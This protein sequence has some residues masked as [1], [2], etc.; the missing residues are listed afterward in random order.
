MITVTARLLSVV[1][2]AF[3]TKTRGG[4]DESPRTTPNPCPRTLDSVAHKNKD[5][6]GR[7][8][9]PWSRH[10][11]R[12]GAPPVP[13][14]V[15]CCLLYTLRSL[16][17]LHPDSE[18]TEQ[19]YAVIYSACRETGPPRS[20]QPKLMCQER[21]YGNFRSLS[22]REPLCV[23]WVKITLEAQRP[24]AAILTLLGNSEATVGFYTVRL[25]R[26]SV[27]SRC[28]GA[29]AARLFHWYP[30]FMPSLR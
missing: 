12:G 15:A 2:Q 10:A 26:G 4:N 27:W 22:E 30:F 23:N 14:C 11:P 17:N 21:S 25:G 29:S 24:G 8:R 13:L 6:N 5:R 28:S 16:I 9:L 7:L 18:A 19:R 1:L 20:P 3:E